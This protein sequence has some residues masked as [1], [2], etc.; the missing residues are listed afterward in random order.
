MTTEQFIEKARK[1]H[2]NRYD[3]SKVKY[4]DSHTKVCIICYTHG[5]FWQ[6]P[7]NHLA[8]NN[9]PNCQNNMKSSTEQFIAKAKQ[10]HG[11]K[12][13]YSKVE[14]INANTKV[15]IICPQH[16]EFWQT[17]HKH[18]NGKHGCTYCS[19]SK[20][21]TIKEFIERAKQIHG[22][23]YDYSKVEYINI[24]TKVC[25]VCPIHGEFWQTPYN[26][27][28]KKCG[29]FECGIES[30]KSKRRKCL[31]QFIEEAQKVH[32]DKYDYSKVEY[33]NSDT[34][35]CII[36]PEHGEFWQTAG[37]HIYEKQG[38]PKCNQSKL[39]KDIELLLKEN[40]LP[41]VYNKMYN[42]LNN[43]QLD[44]YLPQYSIAIECQGRQHFQ[45]IEHFGGEENFK[46]TIERDNLKRQLC[47]EHGIKL[48]YYS[49]LGIE[50]PYKV[51]ENKEE[52]LKEIKEE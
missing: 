28:I 29:C 6:T 30:L 32:G 47:E 5:E 22:D 24:D 11:D 31:E 21:L 12:Y 19:P 48:L 8:G 49:N 52:L 37:N 27:L 17:P 40:N 51:Y 4:I 50:Y 2:G 38:C 45:S 25:I 44:F 20:P 46:L 41:Y 7:N 10:V 36:C 42:F 16:G 14:Y 23:K 18:I 33:V 39:E 1:V 43:L 26:H 13:N 34:K 15:C 3:Y 35:I 9:C